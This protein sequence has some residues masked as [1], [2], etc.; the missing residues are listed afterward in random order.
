MY[1]NRRIAHPP[2]H[3]YWRLK[4]NQIVLTADYDNLYRV[5]PDKNNM[6]NVKNYAISLWKSAHVIYY[7]VA[8]AAACSIHTIYR[9]VCVYIYIHCIHLFILRQQVCQWNNVW[10]VV[11]EEDKDDETAGGKIVCTMIITILLYYISARMS[12]R[13]RAW[14]SPRPDSRK[15]PHSGLLAITAI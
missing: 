8:D 4:L 13:E 9:Y 14:R 12:R 15:R 3:L 10:R 11:E 7:I 1:N 5:R 6:W 2:I